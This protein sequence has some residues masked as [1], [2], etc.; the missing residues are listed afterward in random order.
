MRDIILDMRSEDYHAHEGT[1]HTMLAKM[2]TSPLAFQWAKEHPE[3]P[4]PAMMFGTAFHTAILE[5]E[6][7]ANEYIVIELDR[8]TKVG[9]EAYEN[10][11]SEGKKVLSVAEMEK[12]K[13][14]LSNVAK[15][16][17]VV[18]LLNSPS[19]VSYFWEDKYTGLQCKA[20]ADSIKSLDSRDLLIDV[21]TTTDCSATAFAKACVNYNYDL[22]AAYYT[23]GYTELTGRQC[24]FVFIV[25]EKEPPYDFNIFT[26]NTE[27]LNKGF[28]DMRYCLNLLK[29]C[30]ETGNFYGKNGTD[31]GIIELSLPSWATSLT[32]D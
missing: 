19:E 9:K 29:Q 26:C 2:L 10:A 16:D 28:E 24:D 7:F 21:K 27:M 22:Q 6:R 14:M 25:I 30:K 11:L 5:P 3:E 12:I 32:V 4:T 31:G 18:N 15:N 20:R 1:G 8:R 17:T 23:T 13:S